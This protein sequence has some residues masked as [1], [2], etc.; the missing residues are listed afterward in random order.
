MNGVLF[1]L[2]LRPSVLWE[3][4]VVG[5]LARIFSYLCGGVESLWLDKLEPGA[6]VHES[7]PMLQLHLALLSG[8]SI[9][10]IANVALQDMGYCRFTWTLP[11]YGKSL[12]REL[13]LIAGVCTVLSAT[14]FAL[15]ANDMGWLAP[16]S[17]TLLGFGVGTLL[18]DPQPGKLPG[19]VSAI[20]TLAFLI[21]ARVMA[22]H[23]QAAAPLILFVGLAS[24]TFAIRWST[25]RAALLARAMVPSSELGSA[26]QP[27]DSVSV[28]RWYKLGRVRGWR[29][30]PIGTLRSWM[31]AVLF[32][33]A[34]WMR[35]SWFRRAASI[36]LA[37]STATSLLVIGLGLRRGGTLDNGLAWIAQAVFDPRARID[38]VVSRPPQN[39]MALGFATTVFLLVLGTRQDLRR[40]VLYPLSRSQ[41]ASAVWR[42]GLANTVTG[43]SMTALGFSI[44]G[45]LGLLVSGAPLPYRRVP[46]VIS[47]MFLCAIMIPLLQWF[48]LRYLESASGR[49]SPMAYSAGSAITSGL[50]AA[51]V[52]LISTALRRTDADSAAVLS[53]IT[54]PAFLIFTQYL[55]YRW[56]QGWFGRVDLA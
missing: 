40:G 12:R 38:E 33:D 5:A 4:F 28:Y 31:F 36:G 18:W 7:G 48:R 22:P 3:L 39:M 37:V 25:S 46:E 50:F 32:E 29:C 16:A 51:A 24:S 19:I 49:I 35:G 26:F 43:I 10:M 23:V 56:I 53:Y 8:L 15:F 47:V 41:R 42:A 52:A 20:A 30:G 44:F 9:G 45:V 34:G 13:S 54:L 6:V 11:G 21:F 27:P 1:R 55:Y 17:L 2:F 14:G